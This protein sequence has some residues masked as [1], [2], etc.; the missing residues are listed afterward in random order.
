M[1]EGA[2]SA[3]PSLPLAAWFPCPSDACEVPSAWGVWDKTPGSSRPPTIRLLRLTAPDH[4][5][6]LHP[7]PP[8]Y[9]SAGQ[10]VY[11]PCLWPQ[12]PL[13]TG[14]YVLLSVTWRGGNGAPPPHTQTAN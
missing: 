8:A 12:H 2:T 6:V 10:P 7:Q 11:P 13:P 5:W 9:P 14:V 3:N 1:Q 4:A